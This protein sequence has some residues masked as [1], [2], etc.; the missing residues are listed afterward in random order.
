MLLARVAGVNVRDPESV[1]GGGWGD[2][3]RV[4]YNY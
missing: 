3:F 2:G 1:A 4:S